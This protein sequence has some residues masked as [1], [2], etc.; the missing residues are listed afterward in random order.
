MANT[1]NENG[2]DHENTDPFAEFEDWLKVGPD[3]EWEW[4]PDKPMSDKKLSIVSENIALLLHSE[5]WRAKVDAFENALRQEPDN[6]SREKKRSE[7]EIHFDLYDLIGKPTDFTGLQFPCATSFRGVNFGEHPVKFNETVF[8]DGDVSFSDVEFGGRVSFVGTKFGRGTIDFNHTQF[9]NGDIVFGQVQFGSGET[10]F[11]NACFGHGSVT[12]YRIICGEGSFRFEN[13]DFDS[14]IVI[15]APIKLENTR[16]YMFNVTIAGNLHI[17]AKFPQTADFRGLRV[18][19]TAIF[20]GSKFS[21]VPDF[22]LAKF[23][24]PP[25]VARMDVPKPNMQRRL[26]FVSEPSNK[27]NQKT[28]QFGTVFFGEEVK[29]KEFRPFSVAALKD[30]VAKYRKLKA[31][32]LA[33]NDHEKDGEFFAYEMLAKRGVETITFTG[34]LFNSLYHQLSNFGQS[35]IRPLGWFIVSFIGF[36]TLYYTMIA[37]KYDAVKSVSFALL[38]SFRNAIPFMGAIANVA[39]AP[40]DHT[41]AFSSLFAS[42]KNAGVSIDTLIVLSIF[43]NLIGGVLL[44]LLLL[45][46][47]NK[48]RLK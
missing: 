10:S 7:Y 19:G 3:K 36:A 35:Y 31:M 26:W 27:F 21:Q 30:D 44:F 29:T 16:F 40:A 17:S 34:L 42:I 24:M 43:Q 33:A 28:M 37:S 38:Y 6:I 2:Q 4:R 25:E 41:S 48:F 14:K 13:V 5:R 20:S 45:A 32:A 11:K 39:P 22:R 9:G 23:D 15:F 8:G 46:L 18:G 1:L 12:F 47:R